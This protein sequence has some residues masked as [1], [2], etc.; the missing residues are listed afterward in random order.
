MRIKSPRDVKRV[1]I[2]SFTTVIEYGCKCVYFA[3]VGTGDQVP[4][5]EALGT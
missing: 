2:N 5:E 1:K 3:I 4:T